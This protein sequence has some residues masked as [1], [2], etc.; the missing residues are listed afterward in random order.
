ME[1]TQ[2]INEVDCRPM[3][4]KSGGAIKASVLGEFDR[5]PTQFDWILE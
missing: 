4:A 2:S 5:V 3:T 1:Q